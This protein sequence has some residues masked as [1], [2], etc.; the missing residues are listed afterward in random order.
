MT[1]HAHL[2]NEFTED[3]KNHN[4]MIWLK[5]KSMQVIVQNENGH[6]TPEVHRSRVT[7]YLYNLPDPCFKGMFGPLKEVAL[8]V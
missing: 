2:K 7:K 3:E 8:H 1:A 6:I 5:Y 4:L